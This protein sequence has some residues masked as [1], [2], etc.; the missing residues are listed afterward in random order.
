MLA[1]EEKKKTNIRNSFKRYYLPFTCSN[2][3]NIKDDSSNLN[4]KK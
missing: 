2:I 1:V 4:G 3:N